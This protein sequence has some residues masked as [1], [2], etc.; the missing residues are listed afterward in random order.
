MREH[1]A[2]DEKTR[3]SFNN[4]RCR[5]LQNKNGYPFGY[6]LCK[7]RQRLTFPGGRPPS[8]ISAKELNY[9]VRDGNRCDLFAIATEYMSST[10]CALTLFLC[11]KN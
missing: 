9:C 2:D 6:P 1:F 4:R 8:I 11:V 10:K 3:K 7:F 5:N